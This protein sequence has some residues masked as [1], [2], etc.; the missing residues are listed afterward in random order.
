MESGDRILVVEDE[1]QFRD[2]L[3]TFL[4]ANGFAVDSVGT[5]AEAERSWRMHRPSLAILDYS[6]P[7]GNAIE[8]LLRL[9]SIDTMTPVYILTGRGTIELAV[10]AVKLG[11]EHFVTKPANLMA[12]LGLI[13]KSLAQP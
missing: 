10:E 7:D 3:C 1:L 9:K 6:L 5:S 13:K 8:L 11:A 2:I 4:Q 12:L